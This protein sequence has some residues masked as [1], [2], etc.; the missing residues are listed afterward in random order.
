LNETSYQADIPRIE[1]RMQLQKRYGRMTYFGRGP[2][3]N[4]QDRKASAF[5]D[6]YSS[7]VKDQYVPYI[8]PQENGNKTNVRWAAFSDDNNN[9]VLIVAKK[10]LEGLEISALHMRNEDFDTTSG[11]DYQDLSKT[12]ASKY[13]I[14]I[15]EQD[16]VQ[17]NIDLKQRGVAG[18]DSWYSKPQEKYQIKGQEKY[19]YSYFLIPFEKASK[20]RFIELSKLYANK[21]SN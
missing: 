17:L 7:K 5:V 2:W 10:P 19:N 21:K 4:Y 1:M 8:R 3:G 13:T 11:I 20:E 6:L 12:N 16:L 9:G 15:K 14:D 18:D